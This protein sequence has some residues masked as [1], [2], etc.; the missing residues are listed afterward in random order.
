MIRIETNSPR[1]LTT[2]TKKFIAGLKKVLTYFLETNGFQGD[3]K[4]R[5]I[6][7]LSNL[8]GDLKW[9]RPEKTYIVGKA[10]IKELIW[11][12]NLTPDLS[13]YNTEDIFSQIT[14]ISEMNIR[15]NK[16]LSKEIDEE[17]NEEMNKK[18]INLNDLTDDEVLALMALDEKKDQKNEISAKLAGPAIRSEMAEPTSQKMLVKLTQLGIIERLNFGTTVEGAK[19]RTKAYR[20]TQAGLGLLY[21]ETDERLSEGDT[22]ATERIVSAEMVTGEG[23]TL[24]A[25]LPIQISDRSTEA[26][27]EACDSLTLIVSKIEKA[28]SKKEKFVRLIE[29]YDVEHKALCEDRAKKER[30]IRK[31]SSELGFDL[32]SLKERE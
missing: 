3:W 19:A 28:T 6:T 2:R 7:Q 14:S 10:K 20:I 5:P 18:K 21:P 4:I 15:K 8:Q 16:K 13:L 12:F 30:E 31:L 29:E 17:I 9:I 22:G 11:E 27:M 24:V 25:T 23:K 26:L 1:G 32:E